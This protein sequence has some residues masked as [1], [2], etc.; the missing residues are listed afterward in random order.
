M[1]LGDTLD[2]QRGKW[3]RRRDVLGH[4]V[5]AT[6]TCELIASN[7]G[8]AMNKAVPSLGLIKPQ[9]VVVSVADG[10]PWRTNQQEKAR[11]AAESTLFSQGAVPNELQPMP[12]ELRLKCRCLTSSCNGHDQCLIDWEVGAAAY[13][14]GKDPRYAGADIGEM[15]REKWAKMFDDDLDAHIFVGNQH[16]RRATFSALGVWA[17]KK[18]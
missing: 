14:W 13:R 6:T 7:R 18:G 2:S 11:R 8:T 17:P 4:L 3:T 10:K 5:G 16:Q 15:L 9:D 1:V 12:Y